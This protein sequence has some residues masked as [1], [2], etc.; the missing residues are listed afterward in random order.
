M[1]VIYID[2]NGRKTIHRIRTSTNALLILP[3]ILA[4]SNADRDVFWEAAENSNAT[5]APVAATYQPANTAALLT[6]ICADNTLARVRVPAP[7]LT[8][9]L[10]DQQTVDPASAAAIVATCIGVLVSSSGSLATAFAGGVLEPISG[11]DPF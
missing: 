9:F 7:K 5:P 6:F 11:K 8:L 2:V 10:A 1:S 4:Q 3:Q